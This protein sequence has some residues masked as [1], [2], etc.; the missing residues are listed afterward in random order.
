MLCS[1]FV[2]VVLVNYLELFYLTFS[3]TLKSPYK[4]A[5]LNLE[6]IDLREKIQDKIS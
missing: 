2:F 3:S 5:S 1:F 6:Q 4:N